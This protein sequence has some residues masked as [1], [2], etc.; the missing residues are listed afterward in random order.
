ML[1]AKPRCLLD[2]SAPW[3]A[4]SLSAMGRCAWSSLN[5]WYIHREMQTITYITKGCTLDV[6]APR[7]ASTEAP[8]LSKGEMCFNFSLIISI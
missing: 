8:N 7:K 2:E 6:Q 5:A 4:P 3:Q 1:Q